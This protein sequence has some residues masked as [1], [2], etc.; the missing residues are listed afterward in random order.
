MNCLFWNVN[1]QLI[2][3]AIVN[4]TIENNIEVLALAEYNDDIVDLKKRFISLKYELHEMPNL[5]SRITVLTKAKISSI[6]RLID[7]K[8]YTLFRIPHPKIGNIMFGFTHFFSKS[9]KDENDYTSKASRFIDIIERFEIVN[10]SDNTII[11]GDFNMNPFEKGMLQ[12]GALHAFPSIIEANKLKHTLDEE[13]YKIF[14]NPM[15]KYL[16][17][18]DGVYGTYY[19]IPTHTYG[20]YWNI[21]DQVLYRAPLHNYFE[22]IK[23]VTNIQGETILEENKILLSDH[24][25]I[26]FSLGSD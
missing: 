24:L 5:G 12:G 1:K 2:N 13:D 19:T 23:I 6:E 15:W 4:I 3:E 21:F 11:A 26:K 7:K 9:M 18:I 17:G 22:E 16:G 20:L 14:F 10:A 25:P 8:H